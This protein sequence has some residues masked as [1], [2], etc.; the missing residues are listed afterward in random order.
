VTLGAPEGSEIV[1]EQGLEAGERVIVEGI[2]KV[3]P[4][5]RV[6]PTQAPEATP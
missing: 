1:I 2:Q 4:S 6:A 3:R 5:Q